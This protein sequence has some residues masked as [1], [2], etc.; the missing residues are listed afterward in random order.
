MPPGTVR[1]RESADRAGVLFC[2]TA[3]FSLLVCRFDT[4][5]LRPSRIEHL[6]I[7]A[8]VAQSYRSHRGR[9]S[10]HIALIARSGTWWHSAKAG[11]TTAPSPLSQHAEQPARSAMARLTRHHA[12]SPTPTRRMLYRDWRAEGWTCFG[13]SLLPGGAAVI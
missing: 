13:A 7:I 4:S 5:R 9:P 8:Q 11:K 6:T 12:I 2:C 3:G 1:R 10:E